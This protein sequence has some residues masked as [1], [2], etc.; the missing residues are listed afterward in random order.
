MSAW[1][2]ILTETCILIDWRPLYAVVEV[3]SSIQLWSNT[4]PLVLDHYH[5]LRCSLELRG[6]GDLWCFIEEGL[7]IHRHC[8]RFWAG[9]SKL[10]FH[11][12]S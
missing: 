11:L 6:L 5:R 8:C 10:L 9:A 1:M 12:L 3:E 7:L 4:Q 2:K